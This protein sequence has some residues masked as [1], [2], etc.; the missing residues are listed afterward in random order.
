[1]SNQIN[2]VSGMLKTAYG[3]GVYHPENSVPRATVPT[4]APS[5]PT[6][7]PT[8]TGGGVNLG[9]AGSAPAI[10]DHIPAP[11]GYSYTA[12]GS[13]P[14]KPPAGR[15]PNTRSAAPKS[16]FEKYHGT[17]FDPKSTEDIAKRDA[18][19]QSRA[20]GPAEMRRTANA[21][22]LHKRASAYPGF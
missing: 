7:A 18:L 8:Y 11:K 16:E 6:P 12:P 21:F 13:T 22:P 14:R 20:A 10:P 3:S 5:A 17:S 2:F 15:Y 9:P 4:P 1:M 19:N